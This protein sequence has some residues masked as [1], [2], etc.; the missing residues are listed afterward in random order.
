MNEGMINLEST[1]TTSI[2]TSTALP[3]PL[4]TIPTFVSVSTVLDDENFMVSFVELQFNLEENDI[5]DELIMSSKHFMILNSKINYLLQ[6]TGDTGGR[7]YVTGVEMDYLL[8]DQ[9]SQ[10]WNLIE[11]V[12]QKQEERLATHQ[13]V[14]IMR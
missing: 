1:A 11:G 9:Q 12:E 3:P 5:P 7:N 4:S 10:L 13:S 6:I 2:V 8:K 14:L